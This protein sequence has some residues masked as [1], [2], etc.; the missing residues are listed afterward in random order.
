MVWFVI[1]IIL[2]LI[3][4][5]GFILGPIMDEKGIGFTVGGIALAVAGLF[6]FFASFYQNS[7]GEAQ[8]VVN[9]VDRTVVRTITQPIAGF[10]APWEDF[11]TFDM[12]S[13]DVTYA[14]PPGKA[15]EY[16]KGSVNGAEV[17]VSVGG[18]NGGSTQGDVDMQV[19]YNI[20]P[21]KIKDIYDQYKTQERFTQMIVEKQVLN[22]TRQVPSQYTA[23][24]FRGTKRAEA[25]QKIQDGLNGALGGMGVEITSVTIQDVRYSQPVEDALRAVEVANQNKQAAAADAQSRVIK[26]Q[27][28]AD[29]A[30]ATAKGEAESNRLLNDSLTDKVL[31]SRYIDAIN[32][33][34]TVIVS[35]GKAPV[36]VSK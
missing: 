10:K 6:F 14:G 24:E 33:A 36:I 16:A 29:A 35:D 20:N 25:V 13:Q 31:Q 4:A 2:L 30:V 21:D 32:K 1:A 12:F 19:V 9:S 26:A 11:V 8:V 23:V 3:A 5:A 7:I 22:L 28:E 18:I 15:P 17:T 34:G 27:G